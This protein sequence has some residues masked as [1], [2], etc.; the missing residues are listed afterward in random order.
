MKI[1]PQAA[2]ARHPSTSRARSTRPQCPRPPPFGSNH[3]QPRRI[4][5]SV[6]RLHLAARAVQGSFR[7][8]ASSTQRRDEQGISRPIAALEPQHSVLACTQS[9]RAALLAT[10][11]VSCTVPSLLSEAAYQR[12]NLSA[13]PSPTPITPSH[14]AGRV[15]FGEKVF[16]SL[17]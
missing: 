2:C 7:Q 3:I 6:P 8:R 16:T 15:I 11:C 4:E 5:S 9:R 17:L 1:P 13:C 12:P 10:Q 14:R